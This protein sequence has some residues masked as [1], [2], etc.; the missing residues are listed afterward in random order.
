MDTV[1]FGGGQPLSSILTGKKRHLKRLG[2]AEGTDSVYSRTNETP[3]PTANFGQ[4]LVPI[5]SSY[6]ETGHAWA[7]VENLPISRLLATC[8]ELRQRVMDFLLSASTTWS[9]KVL[10]PHDLPT[11]TRLNAFNALARNAFI[12]DIPVELLE[13]DN[14]ISPF[15]LQGPQSSETR[16]YPSHLAPT[17]LQKR[18]QHHPWLDLFPIPELRDNILRGLEA[19]MYDE[20]HLAQELT[21]DLL[22]LDSTSF[23]SLII[24]GDSWDIS[25]WEFSPDFFRKWAG[26]LDGNPDAWMATDYWRE[27]RHEMKLEFVL[28]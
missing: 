23:P 27:K 6:N 3:T 13:C 2:L 21:C 10:R 16:N 15:L 11:V 28:N 1:L 22:D 14:G 18:V 17:A 7:V 12:L 24:W 19:G 5:S 8:P 9:L 25:G 4:S 20:D 26:L